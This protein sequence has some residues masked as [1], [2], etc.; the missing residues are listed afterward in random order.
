MLVRMTLIA[1]TLFCGTTHA[2][3]PVEG[4]DYQLLKSSAPVTGPKISV[5]DYFSFYCGA[6]K[7]GAP[8]L[9]AW[10]ARLP[11][12]VQLTRVIV[13]TSEAGREPRN[14]AYQALLQ[15][16]PRGDLD[17]AIFRAIQE[18]GRPFQNLDA[19]AGWLATQGVSRE[20]FMAAHDSFA[21]V[22]RERQ[23]QNLLAPLM[24]H[25]HAAVPVITINGRYLVHVGD[26]RKL[27]ASLAVVDA[28][29]E[30]ART[31]MPASR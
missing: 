30:R 17:V 3:A 23:A 18:E 25:E 12:D 15:L 5:V 28:L 16:R 2:A 4:R 9:A 10:R 20:A 11:A 29:I 6:C 13:L 8:R 1:L 21:T 27:D 14:R 24:Q 22:S 7:A 19:F 26:A 31:E